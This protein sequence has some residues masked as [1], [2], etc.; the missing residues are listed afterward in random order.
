MSLELFKLTGKTAWITGGTKGLG[1]QMAQALA[2][3]GANIV[4][5]S[6]HGAEAESAAQA[7]AEKHGV[8]T[9]GLAADVSR[10]DEIEACVARA[11]AEFGGIDIL[12]NNA[13]VNVR[14]PTTEL[15]L[16]DW[17]QVLDINLTGPFLCSRAVLPG[18][19]QRGWGRI[20]NLSS[21]LGMVGLAG[22]PAYTAT[23]G[24]LVL[25]TKTQALEVATTGVTVNAICPG[26][27]ATEMNK[28][29]LDDPEKYAAFVAKIPMGRWGEMHEI[30][31]A[32]IFLASPAAS[33][34]TGTTLLVD[35]GW[36][37]Q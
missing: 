32:V 18:M 5:N 28:P 12:V 13:G 9:I 11:S 37:A 4:V 30:D 8:R 2:G 29:L 7:I 31:G 35:G 16:E 22:R 6:R 27:F 10:A 20:I 14:L 25:L 26:P 24:G 34:V 15:P 36:T 1:L 17:Q 3:V 33:F 21:I 23:K 19:I